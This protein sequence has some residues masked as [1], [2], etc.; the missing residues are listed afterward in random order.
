M[1]SMKNNP[2]VMYGWDGKN[3]FF[4]ITVYHHSANLVMLN[5]EPRDGSYYPTLTLMIY[6][7]TLQPEPR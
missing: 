6:S 5:G 2:L 7:Y 3:S 4:G 1:V